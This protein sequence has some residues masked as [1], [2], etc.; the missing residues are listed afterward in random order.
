MIIDV[1]GW[2]RLLIITD[3]LL[4]TKKTCSDSACHLEV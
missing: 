3:Y 1:C 2:T 4:N